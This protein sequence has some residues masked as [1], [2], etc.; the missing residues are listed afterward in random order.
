[1]KAKGGSAKN[2]VQ[3]AA[4]AKG[5]SEMG[6]RFTGLARDAVKCTTSGKPSWVTPAEW[7]RKQGRGK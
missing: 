7:R 1:M 5:G 3:H 6:T 2:F 4:R